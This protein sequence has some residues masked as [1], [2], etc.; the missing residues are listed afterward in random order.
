MSL[1]TMG[2]KSYPQEKLY[3]IVEKYSL[4]LG[5]A[6]SIDRSSC[7]FE[8]INDHFEKN[9]S[10]LSSSIMEPSFSEKDLKNIVDKAVAAKKSEIG[11]PDYAVNQAVNKIYYDKA[12]PYVLDAESAINEFNSFQREDL[13]KGHKELLNA[14]RISM[15][16][17][18][19]LPIKTVKRILEKEFSSLKSTPHTRNVVDYPASSKESISVVERDIPTAY[20]KVKIPAPNMTAKESSASRLLFEILSEEMAL[21]IRTK[22][23]LSYA[24]YAYTG[25]GQIGL[26]VFSISTPKPKESLDVLASILNRLKTEKFA[27]E[28]FEEYKRT[29]ATGYFLSQ[30]THSSM[31]TMLL[32]SYYYTG[33]VDYMYELPKKLQQVKASDVQELAK[34][35]LKDFK[36]GVLGKKSQVNSGLGSIL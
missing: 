23:S 16:I 18:T 36:V 29:F 7:H 31:T 12:H 6:A 26:G 22:R 28:I 4:V 25:Q 27:D 34:K 8:T 5:C 3:E 9:I 21:E 35:I 2:S 14:D 17:V 10:L 20:I 11:S 30:E 1:L 19:S 32:K 15:A 13:V 33:D 24:A